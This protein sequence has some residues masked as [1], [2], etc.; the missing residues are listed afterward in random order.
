MPAALRRGRSPRQHRRR[1]PERSRST[2]RFETGSLAIAV[3]VGSALL[4][5][6]FALAVGMGPEPGF[7]IGP[8][9]PGVIG[10]AARE[11][12]D[13]E[14]AIEQ[15]TGEVEEYIEQLETADS[16]L[17]DELDRRSENADLPL[18]RDDDIGRLSAVIDDLTTTIQERERQ[19]AENERYRKRLYRI[20]SDPTASHEEKIRRILELGCERLGVEVG[21]IS[22]IDEETGHYEIRAVYGSDFVREGDETVLSKMYCRKTVTS[23]DILGIYDAAAEGFED[24]PSYEELGISCYLGGKIE[25]RNELYGTLCFL[26][27]DSH[28]EPFTTAEKTFVDLM[29]RWVSHEFERRE[30]ERYLEQY[31]TFI[32]DMLDAVDDL[33][34][35]LDRDGTF[36]RW[37]E[38]L[39]EVTGYTHAEIDDMTAL[40]FFDDATKAEIRESMTEAF[41]TGDTRV[42]AKLVTKDGERIP[43]EFTA[44]V[45]ED[46]D[47]NP[48]EVGIGRDISDRKRYER[49]LERTTHLL[50]QAQRLASVGAWELDV[51]DEP[52]EPRWSTETARIHGLPSDD[53]V[54]LE[55]ALAFYHPDDQPKLQAA[56]E[57]AVEDGEP[58]DLELRMTTADGRKRWVRTIGEP[59]RESS[60]NG[61]ADGGSEIVTV[62]GS[63]QD[64]TDRKEREHELERSE[65]IIQA[66]DEL[67]YVLDEEGY[68][69]FLNDATRSLV[70]YEPD[71]LIGEHVS[72]VM[73]RTDIETGQALIREL[74][75]ANEP[76]RTFEMTLVT[77][78]GD[79]IETEN[80]MAL[81]PS[82]DGGF[83]GTAGVVRDITE[84]KERERDLERTTELLEQAER[85]AGIGGWELDV[86]SDP[87]GMIM[88][89]GLRRLYDLPLGE[90]IDIETA[91][92]FPHPDDRARVNEA[93][94][95]AI[96]YGESYDFEHRLRTATGDERWVRSIGEPV[97]ENG[98]IVAVRG[99]IQDITEHKERELA[100]G[101]LH[102]AA[103]DL[104]GADT[105][106]GVAEL[107]VDTADE[108]LEAAGIALYRLDPDVNRLEPIDH[109]DGFTDLCDDIPAVA[110]GGDSAL[111]NAFITGAQTVIDDPAAFDQSQVFGPAVESGVVVPIGDHGV[112]TVVSDS[113][114]IDS[115]A[116]RL[117]ETLVATT[118]AAFDRLESEATLRE[119]DAELEARNRRL[120]RQIAI[121]EIIRRIDQSLIGA[122]S[123][124]EIE[125]TVPERLV[126]ADTVEFAWIGAADAGGTELEPHTWA[127]SS[128]EYLDAVPLDRETSMEPAVQTARTGTPTVVEN[129]VD[130]LQKGTW[131]ASALNAGFQSVI[132]VPLAFEEYTYGVLSV[133]ADEPDAF[134]DL[135]RTVFTELGEGIANA[136]NATKTQEALHTETL[137]ELTL[138]LADSD[139]I[140]SR[141]ATATDARVEYDGLGTHTS[142]ET[143]LFFRTNGAE[144]ATVA[145][146]LDDLVSVT[147]YRL[148]SESD[149]EGRFEATVAGDALVSRLVRH[150][151]SPRSIRA[152]GTETSV[153]V[154]VP[155][156]TDVRE[157]VDMLR[158]HYGTVE[159]RSRR[160]V[161]RETH[162]RR[163]LVSSL[164]EG[165]TDRQLEVLRTAYF[166][167]FFEWPRESTG[168]E[169][170]AM[171]DVSQPTVNRHLRIGHQR[172]LEQL[173]EAEAIAAP[174]G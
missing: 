58:Y 32:D 133:Y 127:G 14:R 36:V 33:F 28:D 72:T 136:I 158:D 147:E 99:S 85:I 19:V 88:T 81:L 57:R 10:L 51:N 42:E 66:L 103:R 62:R 6:G 97:R 144:P 64:I 26:D 9:L 87:Y 41:E 156:G 154:D 65:T 80:H 8:L 138:E 50:E 105:E 142:A 56:V 152:D 77:K 52:Y 17:E 67:I 116:R 48:V 113:G 11:D 115:E 120:R 92:S 140:L 90:S 24:D 3:C 160:H 91:A 55:Q 109:T 100:L 23:D 76:S 108:V 121:T 153:T 132:S 163:E 46:P 40:D 5:I 170:A 63:I 75:A 20:T 166:A 79:V 94:T 7:G 165:L 13:R 155:I 35:V 93:V 167:G 106:R 148:I 22:H 4:G 117:I 34:Y 128:P 173:F 101:S 129:V 124:S 131:R 151:G 161:Q 126:E 18:E 123:R 15:L 98:E 69:R 45:L 38:T 134:T 162:T 107:V 27:R 139:D 174:A 47:G 68:F 86:T 2:G 119:R 1:R 39:A 171:L 49:E 95:G 130:G 141:I 12:A 169:I 71:E 112:F 84:R 104:L 159:L 61:R 78:D 110:V 149:D 137:I 21:T 74:L 111:W 96:E 73:T 118:E 70:G 150:G 54:D 25:V 114:P 53:G 157:F 102:D 125:R 83:A 29:T 59:V 168:E 89:D 164:F 43:Y 135:E 16:E 172:L 60:T 122:E 31:R 30:R 37:N 143:L 82:D 44:S 146:A 145:A